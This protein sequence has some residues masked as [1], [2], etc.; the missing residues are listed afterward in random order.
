MKS[1]R[2]ST[3]FDTFQDPPAQCKP[4]MRWWWF[5]AITREEIDRE[6]EGM[7][8]KHVGGV[9]I[10]PIYSALGGMSID[11]CANVE[12]LSDEW[13]DLVAY[14]ISKAK[15]LGMQVDL[16]FGSG[17]PFGGPH[18][19][20]PMASTRLQGYSSPLVRGEVL[21]ITLEDL[22][23]DVD[24]IES[25]VAMRK[26]KGGNLLQEPVDLRPF[27]VGG[28][29]IVG[30]TVPGD[31]WVFYWYFREPTGQNVKR[32][33][34]GAEGLVLDHL[35]RAALDLH[36]TKILSCLEK[37]LGKS[38][39]D[40]FGAFFCD[41]W[42]VYGENWTRGFLEAFRARVGYDLAP[43]LPLIN[44]SNT[45]VVPVEDAGGLAA[46]IRHDYAEFH[47]R[48][49]LEEFFAHFV[50]I[51]HG[52]GVKARVQPYSAPTDLLR[53]YG[54][55]DILE[56]EGFGR[57]GI[58]TMY[59]GAVDPRLA[60]SGAH[61]YGKDLVSCESFTWLGEHFT[62]S[63]EQIKNEADLIIIHGVNRIIYHG[64]PFSPPAAGVPGWVFY[65]S[66][67][68]NHN[69]TWW[70]FLGEL[71][72]YIS[73]NSFLSMQGRTIADFAVYIPYHDDW[74]GN[75]DILKRLR[76]DLKKYGHL[77]DFDYIN[78][79]RILAGARIEGGKMIVGH[80]SYEF[81]VVYNTEYMPLPVMRKL[82]QLMK[83][84]ARIIFVGRLPDKVPGYAGL[85]SGDHDELGKTM[86][87]LAGMYSFIDSVAGLSQIAGEFG[88]IED[89]QVIEPGGAGDAL[90]Y[91][92]KR[93]T[94]EDLYFVVN[95]GQEGT[96][97]TVHLRTN[98]LVELW[99][100]LKPS[101]TAI[102]SCNLSERQLE[103]SFFLE[104]GGSCWLVVHR[105]M[106][107]R[108]GGL[109]GIGPVKIESIEL[110]DGWRV[111]FV[112]PSN[113]IKS[114]NLKDESVFIIPDTPLFNWIERKEVMYFSGTATYS[115]EFEIEER[116]VANHGKI[117]LNLGLVHEIALVRVNGKVAGSSW[118]GSRELDI[119]SM[120][121]KGRNTLEIE[122]TNLLLNY[123]I[124]IDKKGKKWRPDY[125]FVNIDYK[126]FKPSEMDLLPSGLIGPVIL[127]F[128]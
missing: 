58:S 35:T 120:L 28:R 116:L 64:Y 21:G 23:D 44:F 101:V 117:L 5:S 2:T 122:V 63:L 38:L 43:F 71:N 82:A 89:F 118:H 84:G 19:R 41:S 15:S 79:D 78:D 83:Q 70:P 32:A 1:T 18:I 115:K 54:L 30:W 60:S 96:H 22:C 81:I 76:I 88:F 48:L 49:I 40:S 61:V 25:V 92:H 97:F 107:P 67:M 59:Y 125:Y 7:A 9:E 14:T 109:D 12:W 37:K 20:P 52:V 72:A 56:I 119:S 16:T 31:G 34:P 91:L 77:S 53:A 106:M 10:E 57:H 90:L 29:E 45:S 66:I 124:G 27:I 87:E 108:Q 74:S 4:F 105:D 128:C 33:G 98:G 11:G 121:V 69:N 126:D 104:G 26:D 55:L 113:S 94:K 99:D 36:A 46:A 85:H 51:C 47:G 110:N 39:G 114:R 112:F 24:R 3:L 68:A 65:A 17:W 123:V 111:E 62:V 80:G 8:G 6:L 13:I 127:L 86:K 50:E 103:T 93:T 73:R 100:S 95:T 42:E 102:P 75:K